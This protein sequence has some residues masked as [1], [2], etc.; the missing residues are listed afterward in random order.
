MP[1]SYTN[2]ITKETTIDSP[3]IE[4]PCEPYLTHECVLSIADIPK[5]GQFIKRI[6][7]DEY[8]LWFQSKFL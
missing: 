2:L 8:D 7:D 5:N 3:F 1:Y 6:S 4:V